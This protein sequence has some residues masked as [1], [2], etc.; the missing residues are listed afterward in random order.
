LI[1]A[2]KT[3]PPGLVMAPI[4]TG[5]STIA[6]T[7]HRLVAGA[8]HR[9]N[10]GNLAM[11]QFYLGSPDHAWEEARKLGLTY[12]VNCDGLATTP[13]ATSLARNLTAG[14]NPDWLEPA[15]R[16]SDGAVL[17]RVHPS[18]SSIRR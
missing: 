7:R 13:P 14:R 18:T 1:A 2:L 9:N 6:A 8:Y 3:V 15:A 11:Y 16:I 5:G 4:D 12:V 10:A 17:Y